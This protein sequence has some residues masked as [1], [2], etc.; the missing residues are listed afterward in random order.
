MKF[1]DYFPRPILINL[2]RRQDRLE[3]FD[4]DAKALGITYERLSAV[5]LEDP[6]AGCKA[7]HL[8]ALT[9]YDDDIT[10]IIEDDAAFVEDFD[11][12]FATSMENLP[13]DWDMLYLGAHLVTTE[14]ANHYWLRSKISSSTHA[15]AVKKDVKAAL[16]ETANNY[17]GHIDVAYSKLHGKLKAYIARPTLVYQRASFS[18]IRGEEVDYKDL[19]FR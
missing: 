10:F 2:D 4:K 6:V 11:I 5:E 3:Q 13:D 19:Y 8:L 15:Y 7:S 16:I 9:K 1:N 12:R 17:D 14:P 18:D